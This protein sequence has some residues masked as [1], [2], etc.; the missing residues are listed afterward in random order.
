MLND[1][2]IEATTNPPEEPVMKRLL[3]LCITTL[4]LTALLPGICLAGGW[5]PG[6]ILIGDALLNGGGNAAS[7]GYAIHG[8][9]LGQ[10]FSGG[11]SGGSY[12]TGTL[13]VGD[14]QQ[15]D[16]RHTLRVNFSGNGYGTVTGDAGLFCYGT[17]GDSC[18]VELYFTT[19]VTLTASPLSNSTFTGWSGE[20]C[21]GTGSC[22]VAMGTDRTVTA[23][24]ASKTHTIT[25]TA[26]T[27][28]SITPGTIS[29]NE[30][31]SQAFTVT[32]DTGYHIAT[33]T[34]DGNQSQTITNP[35]LLNYTFSN[36]TTDGHSISST[37]AIDT[38]TAT[39]GRCVS[40]STTPGYNDTPTY[41]FAFGFY[42]VAYING[43]AVS[44]ANS[45]YTYPTG[46]IAD[47][48]I[49]GVFTVIPGGSDPVQLVHGQTVD[50]KTSLQAAYNAAVT[51]DVILLKGGTLPGTLTADLPIDVT[52]KG[53]YN[54][55][56]TTSCTSTKVGKITV[57]AGTV[58]AQYISVQ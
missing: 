15:S 53:G 57:K 55:D 10:A 54:S 21:D 35:K 3:A 12:R 5:S 37:Y 16:R 20:G 41:T 50:P 51:G 14:P 52:I 23:T 4:S 47:Q 26:G 30:G 40:G 24:F 46:V 13:V 56:Y 42:V 36:V 7:A 31:S 43:T 33:V 6:Y 9:A 11:M 39:L 45:S 32:P 18:G 58:R 1:D 38:F 8:S 19:Q 48:S 44:L 2:K 25:A 28:G 22:V 17:Q 27:H 34:V 29:V 49:S